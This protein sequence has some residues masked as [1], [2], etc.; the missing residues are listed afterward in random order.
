MLILAKIKYVQN[1]SS[2]LGDSVFFSFY[3]ITDADCETCCR[4][5]ATVR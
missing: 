1:F 4:K 5:R 3:Y 2:E